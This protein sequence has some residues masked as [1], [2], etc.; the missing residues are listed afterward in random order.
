MEEELF[1]EK[2]YQ[3]YLEKLN[4]EIKLPSTFFD[5]QTEQERL[6]YFGSI[7]IKVKYTPLLSQ[8]ANPFYVGFGNFNAELLI[9]GQEKAFD[10]IQDPELLFHE[11]INNQFQWS[12]I[13]K[14]PSIDLI[15]DPRNPRKYHVGE[16]KKN[17]TWY[18]YAILVDSIFNIDTCKENI[19]LKFSPS[20]KETLFDKAFLTEFNFLPSK[21]NNHQKSSSTERIEFLKM[22]ILPKF[23][24]IVFATGT[25]QEELKSI[26]PEIE[27]KKECLGTY[28]KEYRKKRLISI[29]QSESQTIIIC[30]QLSGSAGWTNDHIISM[31][32]LLAKL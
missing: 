14:N 11:S 15:F 13:I 25:T 20:Q 23:K 17:H 8:L 19:L 18:K 12:Q 26:F 10:S 7:I 30:N 4:R 27:F 16:V 5:L 32:Q 31:G 2:R 29:G 1:N 6:E 22:S 24:R 28:G 21:R 3:N 9:I